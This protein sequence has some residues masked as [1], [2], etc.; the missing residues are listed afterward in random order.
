MEIPKK[1]DWMIRFRSWA[2]SFVMEGVPLPNVNPNIVSIL[3]VFAAVSAFLYGENLWW[4]FSMILLSLLLD[5][6]DGVIAR[7]YNRVS[8]RGYWIDI[9]C[10]RLN[11]LIIAI[12]SPLLWLPMFFLN[13]ILTFLNHKTNVH[14]IMPLRVTFLIFLLFKIFGIDFGWI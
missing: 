8:R 9:I 1:Y 2:D 3:S 14:M 6:L 12:Y 5:W 7:K 4:I 11:E 10:D 13:L